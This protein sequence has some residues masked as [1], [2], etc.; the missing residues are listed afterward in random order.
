MTEK[1]QNP[2]SP[3]DSTVRPGPPLLSAERLSRTY[4]DGRVRALDDVS[5]D[6]RAGEYVAVTGPSGSG[7]STLLNL[8]GALD[9]P[10]SGEIY[11]DGRPYSTIGRFDRLR[12]H[13]IGFV[14]QAF[15]LLPTLTVAENVQIPM[16]ETSLVAHQRR[17]KAAKLLDLVGME[18]RATH[19]PEQLSIGERQRV[20]IARALAND[21]AVLLAD[22]PTGNLDSVNASGIFKLF[23]QL[24]GEQGITILLV[25]HNSELAGRAERLLTM[26]DGRILSD[27]ANSPDTLASA[28]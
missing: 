20:A 10:T 21:P 24:R 2:Q 22:E 25:T 7:K 11:F 19:R 15:Y 1:P 4:T 3:R 27:E 28:R 14:F 26:Q 5:L 8:L 9:R 23:D 6:I 16:F 12:A 17:Q 18:H 13:E